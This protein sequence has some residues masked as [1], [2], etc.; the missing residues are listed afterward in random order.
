MAVDARLLANGQDLLLRCVDAL[1]TREQRRLAIA[2]A[3]DDAVGS[4]I[5]GGDVGDRFRRVEQ[6]YLDGQVGDLVETNGIESR[7]ANRGGHHI[8]NQLARRSWLGRPDTAD[9]TTQ[10]PVLAQS[11]ENG[12]WQLEMGG[13]R[14]GR[15]DKPAGAQI[16]IDGSAAQF[17]DVQRDARGGEGDHRVADPERSFVAED[18]RREAGRAGGPQQDG[19]RP[20]ATLPRLLDQIRIHALDPL[21]FVLA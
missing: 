17:L 4:R 14:V 21:P 16:G 18:A 2:P 19:Q 5:E 9:T 8:P 20:Q 1:E 6:L 3:N 7:V 12:G 11:Y 10:L 13:H 15:L